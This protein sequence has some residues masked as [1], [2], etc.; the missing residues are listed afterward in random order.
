MWWKR[1]PAPR[2]T[3]GM[4]SLYPSMTGGW[5]GQV[6]QAHGLPAWDGSTMAQ[7]IVTK[8]QAT[9]FGTHA[10]EEDR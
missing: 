6:L 1:R 7:P 4:A 3:T 8:G 10:V 5:A 9:L 2:D